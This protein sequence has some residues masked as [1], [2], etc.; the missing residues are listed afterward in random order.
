METGKQDEEQRRVGRKE[1]KRNE[2][3]KLIAQREDEQ[4]FNRNVL[5]TGRTGK[6]DNDEEK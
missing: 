1:S 3:E 2:S 6:R 5:R 4:G